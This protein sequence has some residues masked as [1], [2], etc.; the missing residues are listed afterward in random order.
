MARVRITKTPKALSGLE[1]KMKD[2]K[3]GL[4]G[5]NG[6]RQFS[7][8][9]QV[10]GQRFSEP[11]IDVRNTLQPVAR[12][13]ANLEAEKGETAIVN[14]DGMPAHFKIG[15]KRHSQGGTPLNLPDNSFI[16]SDTSK[17]KIKDLIIQAQ[18]GMVPNK[19]GYTPAEISKKYDINKFRKVLA[20]KNSESV[21]RKTAEMMISNY[22]L[23]LAKLALIQESMKGFPQGIPLVAMPYIIENEM[24]AAKFLPDQAQEQMEGEAQP[25]AETGEA[26]Y[27]ANVVSTWDTHRFGGMPK[28]QDGYSTSTFKD[29]FAKMPKTA[30]KITKPATEKEDLIGRGFDN[31]PVEERKWA[32]DPEVSLYYDLYKKAQKSGH[33]PTMRAAAKKIKD[34]DIG[35]WTNPSFAWDFKSGQNKL[36]DLA[37]IL[38]EDADALVNK[39][40]K[41]P[42]PESVE[43]SDAQKLSEDIIKRQM[44]ADAFTKAYQLKEKLKREGNPD[45]ALY[46]DDQVK[47]L[48]ELHPDYKQAH[49]WRQH[50]AGQEEQGSP[51]DP[52][53]YQIET[54]SIYYNKNESHK[55]EELSTKMKELYNKP[56]SEQQ[57]VKEQVKEEVKS[58][59]TAT[60]ET[61]EVDEEF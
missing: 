1:V 43:G 31:D 29:A 61:V 12:E 34:A 35:S 2:M 27:G 38:N 10:E 13:G 3:P 40:T 55:I 20:D 47:A 37:K 33:G 30:V 22:N 15:G 14:V 60:I 28:A 48:L 56:V 58:A 51:Y 11:A 18:F 45:S 50:R 32:K 41:K 8:S 19:A 6:N 42:A 4:Y 16:Y 21:E 7:L 5:T 36:T 46:Y 52:E 54:P 39:Y 59:P 24:D 44:A 23:K 9:N 17:M 53:S 25:D 26:R 57:Q 49:K